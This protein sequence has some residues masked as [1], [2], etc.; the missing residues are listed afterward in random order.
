MDKVSNARI[1]ELCGVTKWLNERIDEDVLLRFS[2][3]GRMEN[4]KIAECLCG[5]VGW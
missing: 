4:Y 3:V 2:Y 5:G 1:R